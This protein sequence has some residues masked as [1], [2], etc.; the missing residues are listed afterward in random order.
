MRPSPIRLSDSVLPP[1]AYHRYHDSFP[2]PRRATDPIE[3]DAHA[4]RTI[5]AAASLAGAALFL[6]FAASSPAQTTRTETVAEAAAGAIYEGERKPTT[7][8]ITSSPC[9][10]GRPFRSICRP[11]TPASTSTFCRQGSEEA[12][13]IGSTSGNVADIPLP[14]AG[15]YVVRDYP[16]RNAARRDEAAKYALGIGLAGADFAD[17]LAGG[18]DWWQVSGV[19]DGDALNIHPRPATAEVV[20]KAQNGELMQNRGCRMTGAERWCNIRVYGS[21]VQGW[22]AGKYLIETAAPAMPEM[23]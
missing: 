15:N 18:P 17:G 14:A 1:I 5:A 2:R 13:F 9:R 23:P 3:G 22:V 12:L 19:G 10:P 8:W 11:P 7:A 6:A 16:M 20:S 21:G 4:H